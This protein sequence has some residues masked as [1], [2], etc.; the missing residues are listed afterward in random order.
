MTNQTTAQMTT[1]E[2]KA[3]LETIHVG[4]KITKEENDRRWARLFQLEDELKV[5]GQLQYA[6]YNED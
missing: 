3:E 1:E 4:G 2:I 5:R 6:T